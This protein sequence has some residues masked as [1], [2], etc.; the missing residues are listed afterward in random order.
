MSFPNVQYFDIYIE[1][2]TNFKTETLQN[3]CFVVFRGW[4]DTE[5]ETGTP[6]GE[7]EEE[8]SE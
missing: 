1:S 8:S 7:D 5:T 3:V 4:W 6:D 2:V